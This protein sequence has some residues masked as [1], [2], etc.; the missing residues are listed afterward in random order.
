[1]SLLGF[2]VSSGEMMDEMNLGSAMSVLPASV[3]GESM[4]TGLLKSA[5]GL[6]RR[7]F[8][9]CERVG[10]QRDFLEALQFVGPDSS[11]DSSKG[12]CCLAASKMSVSPLSSLE[13]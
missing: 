1:M 6:S 3:R 7:D 4:S 5:R 8:G 9:A 2:G 13:A 11:T 10:L 12:S